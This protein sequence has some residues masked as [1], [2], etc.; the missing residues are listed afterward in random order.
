VPEI[1]R[2]SA[3]TAEDR[4]RWSVMIP[5]Y[6]CAHFLAQALP[7]VVAQ[8]ADRDD[9]EIIV[10]DDTSK[11]DPAGVVERLG[12]GRVRYRPNPGHLGAIGTFNR[13][14]ELASGELVHLLHGDDAV[15]PGFYPAMEQALSN[16][17]V[18]AAVCRVRDVDA[19]NRQIYVTRSYRRGTGIWT[20]ALD[21]FAVS[22]RVRAPG[23]VVR[24]TAY[25]RVGGYRTDLPHAADWD[26]WTRLAAH[27][28]IV[29]VDQV[30]AV[31]R[32]HDAS[33]TSARVR[34]GANIRERVTAI[35]V[36]GGYVAPNR[37]AK[38]TRRALAYSV[39]FASRTAMSLVRVGDWSA[40]RTQ[41]R[42]A[43]RCAWLLPRGL[44]VNAQSIPAPRK[45]PSQQMTRDRSE[46]S[47]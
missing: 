27:G 45:V 46:R 23:I 24:R 38:T 8:L 5:V 6:N 18:L 9:A 17:A 25:E 20:D 42:Q 14:L 36:L 40:A 26:M 44:P 15:L 32:R 1:A 30:L 33:D 12:R 28:P 16:P 21:A 2:I 35:G 3:V 31:Y 47:S 29:F 10:V 39:V 34:T 13:C 4:P 19:H 11:D 22:N 7:E 43:I 37:R 41:L